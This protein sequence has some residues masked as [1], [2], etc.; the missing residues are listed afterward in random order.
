M[1]V[2]TITI[3]EPDPEIVDKSIFSTPDQKI[4]SP[5]FKVLVND[6]QTTQ[7]SSSLEICIEAKDVETKEACLGFIDESVNPPEWKC[8]DEC[9]D[10]RGS[11]LCG[12]TGHT[13][14]F[15]ILLGG[16]GSGNGDG[17][18]SS[19]LYFTGDATW[20]SLTIL[21]C[22]L[23]VV[24]VAVAIILFGMTP[25]GARILYGT[26]RYTVRIVSKRGIQ[27]VKIDHAD[28][29]PSSELHL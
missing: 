19:Y 14:N 13:T 21:F 25:I 27:S 28:A 22:I 4:A 15:A 12:R 3:N 29:V 16:G 18:G 5:V 20:D 23:F 6:G 2:G 10:Q 11:L 7:F 24:F 8:E 26:Q 1:E 17:C 9:L